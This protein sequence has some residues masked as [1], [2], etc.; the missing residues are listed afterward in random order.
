MEGDKFFFTPVIDDDYWA[1]TLDELMFE[2]FKIDL[3]S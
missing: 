2:D 3:Y 1:V